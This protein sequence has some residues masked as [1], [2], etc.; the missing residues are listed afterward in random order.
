MWNVRP[1]HHFKNNHGMNTFNSQH[2]GKSC[3]SSHNGGYTSVHV[4]SKSYLTHRII[5]KLMTGEDPSALIDHIDGDKKNNSFP[6][7]RLA[8]KQQNAYNSKKS[9]KNKSGF[10]GVSF[11]SRRNKY[12]ACINMDGKTISLGRHDTPELAHLAYVEA[13]KNIH[14]DFLRTNEL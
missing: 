4:L 1:I 13:A 6:N 14:G 12:Y 8:T 11:D 5:W 9:Y 10:K 2:S 7:L 3:S